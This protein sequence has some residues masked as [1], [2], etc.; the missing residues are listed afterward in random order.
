MH[1]QKIIADNNN[2][3]IGWK[4]RTLIAQSP[5]EAKDI[6]DIQDHYMLMPKPDS[7]DSVDFWKQVLKQYEK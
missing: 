3:K 4:M 1:N 2:A 6:Q 5:K 7:K